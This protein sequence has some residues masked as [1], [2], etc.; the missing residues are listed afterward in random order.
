MSES[1]KLPT[2]VF[3]ISQYNL[4]KKCGEAYKR[5]YVDKIKSPGSPDS[6][7]G[8]LVHKGAEKTHLSIINNK[9]IPSLEE[10]KA[11]MSDEYDRNTELELTP[12]IKD[13]AL[14]LYALYHRNV[15]PR[16]NP[17]AAEKHFNVM[18]E[19]EIPIQGYIDLL[20][21]KKENED[22]PGYIVVVDIK[23]SGASWSQKDLDKDPQFT[24]YS[25][26][27]RTPFVR[28]ENL[29]QLKTGPKLTTLK[30]TRKIEDQKILIE[31]LFETVDLIK[32]G[33]FPKAAI[34]SWGCNAQW[35][36]YWSDCRGKAW[37]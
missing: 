10:I 20:E 9:T 29:V 1:N 15:V 23:T 22:D 2:G 27:E 31:D 34:E 32:K 28:V 12:N 33:I 11:V 26:V 18:L 13:D 30:A 37:S 25:L 24:L 3:S 8:T 36:A 4:F 19:G 6:F 14:R 17:I 7:K 5:R 21:E 16:L 35:C